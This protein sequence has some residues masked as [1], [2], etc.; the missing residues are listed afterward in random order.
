MC[1][2]SWNLG[3]W[4]SWNPLSLSRPVHGLLYLYLTT[5]SNRMRPSVLRYCRAVRTHPPAVRYFVLG[6]CGKKVVCSMSLLFRLTTN[7]VI[8]PWGTFNTNIYCYLHSLQDKLPSSR[9]VSTCGYNN[10]SNPRNRCYWNRWFSRGGSFTL[11]PL[12][13]HLCGVGVSEE[14]TDTRVTLTVRRDRCC[15][16]ME[17]P[18]KLMEISTCCFRTSLLVRS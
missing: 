5:L 2:L 13:C 3:A 14:I 6:R 7:W 8:R 4:T 1:R 17:K 9:P 18:L 16:H 12:A 11:A 15:C 10:N